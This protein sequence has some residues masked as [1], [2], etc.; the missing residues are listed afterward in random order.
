MRITSSVGIIIFFLVLYIDDIS[1]ATIDIC[2]LH[3]TKRFL[4]N[5]FEM[6][7]LGDSSFVLGIPIHRDY[8]QSILGLSQMSYIDKVLKRFGM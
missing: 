1:L 3:D 5:I 2:L 4:S 6:K 8:S 7:D